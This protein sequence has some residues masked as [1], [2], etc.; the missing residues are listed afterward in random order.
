[1][2]YVNKHMQALLLSE[3][4][5]PGDYQLA[6]DLAHSGKIDLKT[7]VTHRC[8][9]RQ[10]NFLELIFREDSSSKMLQRHWKQPGKVSIGMDGMS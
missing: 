8:V 5:Q 9:D 1:M 6:I 4:E 2:A 10:E 7:L 3:P